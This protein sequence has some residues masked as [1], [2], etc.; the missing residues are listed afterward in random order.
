MQNIRLCASN[1]NCLEVY[2]PKSLSRLLALIGDRTKNF[3]EASTGLAEDDWV[4]VARTEPV[5]YNPLVIWQTFEANSARFCSGNYDIPLKLVVKDYSL[6]TGGH[7]VIGTVY[8]TFN[9][10]IQE[11]NKKDTD[12]FAIKSKKGADM[13]FLRVM[14]LTR[15]T[16]RSLVKLVA[17][18][19][20]LKGG[21]SLDLAVGIDFSSSNKEYQL[22]GSR[23]HVSD[24]DPSKKNAYQMV[25]TAFVETFS[26]L[27]EDK[28]VRMYGFGAKL[29]Y[30]ELKSEGVSHCFP[31]TGDT[32]ENKDQVDCEHGVLDTYRYA[33]SHIEFAG[34][35]Y[36]SQLLKR[37]IQITEKTNMV[38]T[39]K[40]TVFLVI[41]DGMFY[42]V[43]DTIDLLVEACSKPFSLLLVGLGDDHKEFEGFYHLASTDFLDSKGRKPSR[44]LCRFVHYE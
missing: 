37:V 6:K 13:G 11:F 44:I 34:P 26:G 30:P 33:L 15:S 21:L 14:Q 38:N 19:D 7:A 25:I 16:I 41:T 40:Y 42:D 9:E 23:H 39:E 20:C 24:L 2:K 18:E 43:Q 17:F 31:C 27:T 4:L 28:K 5:N 36:F 29:N 8:R 35:T 12:N 32:K 10:L 1:N 3:D 22:E